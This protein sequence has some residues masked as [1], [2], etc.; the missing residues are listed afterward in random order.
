MRGT[1]AGPEEEHSGNIG[2]SRSRPRP[3]QGM[4][5]FGNRPHT[6]PSQ[7]DSDM[8]SGSFVPL[9]GSERSAISGVQDLGPVSDQERIEVTLIL[10]RRA[11]LPD[12]LI[13]SPEVI[14]PTELA[15][16]YG[17]DPADVELARDTLSGVRLDGTPT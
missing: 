6:L 11:E 4:M 13:F 1:P 17:A 12:E 7:E 16:T 10:R 5:L 2:P 3:G 9:A 15:D 14:S 8:T